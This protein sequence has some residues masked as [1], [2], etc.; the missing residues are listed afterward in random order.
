KNGEIYG[1]YLLDEGINLPEVI[2]FNFPQE[3][4]TGSIKIKGTNIKA[5]LIKQDKGY[6]IIIP[7]KLQQNQPSQH[8]VVFCL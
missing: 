5:K 1:I 2:E 8:A 6:K 7:K 3:L 4:K